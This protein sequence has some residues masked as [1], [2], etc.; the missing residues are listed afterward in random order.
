MAIIDRLKTRLETDISDVELQLVIDEANQDII[1]TFGP[2]ADPAN[3]I[4]VRFEGS[5]KCITMTR[6]VD[7]AQPMVVTEFITYMS[8]GETV[9][10]MNP[11]D[12]RVWPAGYTLERLQIGQNPRFEWAEQ[13]L[14]NYVPINDGD[15]REEV[16][17]KMAMLAVNWDTVSTRNVGRADGVMAT[18]LDYHTERFK[19]LNS[20]QPWGGL[21]MT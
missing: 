7:V 2:H 1:N 8:W 19:L 9:T 3:P 18:N 12:Y 14:V 11:N 4:S 20:L 17:L 6:P 13:V 16:I 15:K 10:V 5:R 21:N